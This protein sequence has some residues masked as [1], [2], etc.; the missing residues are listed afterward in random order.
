LYFLL[1]PSEE[2]PDSYRAYVG[3]VGRRTL[4]LRTKE[5]VGAKQWWS[6]ALLIASASDEFNSAEIGWLGGRLYVEPI[7]AARSWGNRLT[8]S[9]GSCS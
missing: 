3:E 8:R 6:R 4:V 2:G 1:G 5:H 9:L 7:M